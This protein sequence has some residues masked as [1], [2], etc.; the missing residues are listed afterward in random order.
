[1]VLL[2][3]LA[4]GT[5]SSALNKPLY[6]DDTTLIQPSASTDFSTNFH[7]LLT[8]GP[9]GFGEKT[10]RPVVTVSYLIDRQLYGSRV[11]GFH[12]TNLIL[13]GFAAIALFLFLLRYVGINPALVGAAIFC[14]HPIVGNAVCFPGFRDDLLVMVFG[15]AALVAYTAA[16]RRD[17]PSRPLILSSLLLF[18]AF[19]SKESAMLLPAVFFMTTLVEA[20]RRAFKSPWLFARPFGWILGVSGIYVLFYKLSSDPFP[21]VDYYGQ[22]VAELL[23]TI[24]APLG[25]AVLLPFFPIHQRLAY[26][27]YGPGPWPG[28]LF[29]LAMFAVA[30]LVTL[31]FTLRR[32]E[33]AIGCWFFL[34]TYLPTSNLIIQIMVV[35]D[36]RFLYCSTAGL[37]MAVTIAS[38]LS[39]GFQNIGR[40][41]KTSLVVGLLL[42]FSI[43]SIHRAQVLSNPTTAWSESVRLSPENPQ[44]WNRLAF[45]SKQEKDY[46]GCE[47]F[48]KKALALSP[49]Y[50]YALVS[51]MTCQQKTGN[52]DDLLQVSEN[53]PHLE[54][55]PNILYYRALAFLFK[56]QYALAKKSLE[57]ALQTDPRDVQCIKAYMATL[58]STGDCRG[59]RDFY[60]EKVD[61]LNGRDQAD[62]RSLQRVVDGCHSTPP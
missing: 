47:R 49:G 60:R 21:S 11:F 61:L 7:R 27:F 35:F 4:I 14:V 41:M 62:L 28:A 17:K 29:G 45:Q 46:E 52:F 2:M 8:E 37:V 50:E 22:G 43:L 34:A 48:A 58:R 23:Q 31:Y 42:V 26:D 39:K 30:A 10:L 1:M 5:W 57:S 44:S 6:F 25:K 51:L 54:Q 9:I 16:L 55:K 18:L 36:E 20:K 3:V 13:H 24:G 40:V 32:S 56:K 38:A 19:L 15:T 59:L 33:I 53:W 12:L